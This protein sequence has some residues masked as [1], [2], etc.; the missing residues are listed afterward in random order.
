MK[1]IFE[2]HVNF[3][4]ERFPDALVT[5]HMNKL[6]EEVLELQKAF[7]TDNDDSMPEELADVMLVCFSIADSMG[8]SY[9]QMCYFMKAKIIKN[10]TRQWEKQPD[11][12][13]KHKNHE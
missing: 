11:G 4:N 10:N 13:Y 1:Q 8:M 2:D 5:G 6:K 9:D 7:K 12:T 3:V